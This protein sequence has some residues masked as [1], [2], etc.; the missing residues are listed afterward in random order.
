M[1]FD[2]LAN[3]SDDEIMAMA[4]APQDAVATQQE[5][6]AQPAADPALV[7]E[8]QRQ[9][10]EVQN[11]SDTSAALADDVDTSAGDA[12]QSGVE[13]TPEQ[14]AAEAEAAAQTSQEEPD[15]KTLYEGLIKPL[16]ANGKEIQLQSHDELIQ[17]AQMGANYTR[18][19]QQLAP[20][21]KT[22]QM[23]EN[24]NL[25]DPERLGFLIDL[26]RKDPAAIQKYLK[27]S[28]LN[29]L[30]IDTE[31]E[32]TYQGGR[33]EVTDAQVAFTEAVRDARSTE[34]GMAVLQSIDSTWDQASKEILFSKPEVL[35]TMVIQHQEGFYTRI[36]GEMERRRMLGRIPAGQSWL[37]SYKEVGEQM[38]QQ[39]HFND[40]VAPPQEQRQTVQ[41]TAAA[42][43]ATRVH[44]P[45]PQTAAA[46]KAAAA[47][48]S[49]VTARTAQ[50]LVNPLEMSDE[51][52]MKQFANRL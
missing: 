33:H 2:D 20:H 17:L 37:E 36:T 49:K 45:K 44:T 50:T 11:E 38:A 40:L 48:P 29:P 28:G 26:Q 27:D 10:E 5:E 12:D 30:D 24:N 18:K 41:P 32:P 15:Y 16:K 42:P 35:E 47:A 39:G 19:M 14:I 8:E 25:L 43:V 7:Q 4:T 51:E 31:A 1:E 34:V 22:L 6:A 21:R 13:K 9:E 3:M 23:L 52:F 46:A